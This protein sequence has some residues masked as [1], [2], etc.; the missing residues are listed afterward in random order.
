MVNK[1]E[2]KAELRVA[3][4][5]KLYDMDMPI[6]AEAIE[7]GDTDDVL[8]LDKAIDEVYD[9]FNIGFSK[10]ARLGVRAGYLPKG[11]K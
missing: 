8:G 2:F 10:L 1:Q 9:Y 7:Y 5:D 3:L 6:L 4:A 11:D